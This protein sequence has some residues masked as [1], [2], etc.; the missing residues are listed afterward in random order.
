MVDELIGIE[1]VMEMLVLVEKYNIKESREREAK[2][3]GVEVEES[4]IQDTADFLRKLEQVGR[5]SEDE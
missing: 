5:L 1:S 4:Y 2:K 3:G